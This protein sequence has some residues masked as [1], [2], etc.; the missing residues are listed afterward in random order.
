MEETLKFKVIACE[1]MR[2]EIEKLLPEGVR[3]N[4]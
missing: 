3:E 2:K 4:R 1:T